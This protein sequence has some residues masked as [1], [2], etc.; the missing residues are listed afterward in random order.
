MSR[1][2]RNR[3]VSPIFTVDFFGNRVFPVSLDVS[4]IGGAWNVFFDAVGGRLLAFGGADG[5]VVVRVDLCGSR[6]RFAERRGDRGAFV[7]GC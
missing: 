1:P 4:K 3:G 7:V 6:G 5:V 2:S